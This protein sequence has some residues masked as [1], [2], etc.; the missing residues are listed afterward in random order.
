MPSINESRRKKACRTRS[1]NK[2]IKHKGLSDITLT[3]HEVEIFIKAFNMAWNAR[4]KE[5]RRGFE[6]AVYFAN[7]RKRV[8]KV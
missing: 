8:R 5:S 6:K 4:R 7:N 1:L 3:D 2:L